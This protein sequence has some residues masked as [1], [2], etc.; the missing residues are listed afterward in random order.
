MD[1]Y[2]EKPAI[3]NK[4]MVLLFFLLLPLFPLF[5]VYRI[6]KHRNYSHKKIKDCKFFGTFLLIFAL[7]GILILCK[8]TYSITG[9]II[10]IFLFMSSFA[11]YIQAIRIRFTLSNRCEQ[12]RDF[13]YTNGISSIEELARLTGQRVKLVKNDLQYLIRKE[14]LGKIETYGDRILLNNGDI[15]INFTE[16]YVFY[17]ETSSPEIC[18]HP[19]HATSSTMKNKK[20]K[21]A[22]KPKTI[23]CHGCG[24]SIT[25]IDGETKQC[26]YCESMVS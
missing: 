16:D 4:V 1:E 8:S 2:R 11:L 18:H 14:L 5:V 25:L 15:H 22:P 12:Y 23:Q 19:S 26:E 6:I 24:A 21:P 13:I 7:Y 10:D 20:V 17:V 9:L 3:S